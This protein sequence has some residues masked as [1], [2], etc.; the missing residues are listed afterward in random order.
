VT[1]IAVVIDHVSKKFRRGQ[2]HDSLRDLVP[3]LARR[4]IRRP[5]PDE[6]RGQEFWALR[7]VHFEVERGQA[8][9]IVG[10]NGAGKSTILKLLCGIIHPT[11]GSVRVEGRRSGLL[12]IG[13]GFH[14]DL[15]GRENIFLNGVILG[16]SR[17]E[18]ERK[19]DEI[20]DFS[21]VAEFIDTPVKRYSSGMFARLGFSVA[22]HLEPDILI[23]DEVLSVGDF[24]FQKKSLAKMTALAAGGA[25]VLFVSH[26]LKAVVDLCQHCA[27][28][29]HGKV[30][31]IGP[32]S[33]V[34]HGYLSKEREVHSG[35][36]A[37]VRI[38]R[39]SVR[40]PDGP[41]RTFNSG[42]CAVVDVELT[43]ARA[44]KGLSV[45][46]ALFDESFYG[47]FWATTERLGR[48]AFSLD[49]GESAVV[50]FRL[51]LHLGKGRFDIGAEVLRRD[52]Q[53]SYDRWEHAASIF[54]ECER[55]AAGVVDL[56]PQAEVLGPAIT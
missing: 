38:S 34:L 51:V 17:R 25:T 6:L 29:D 11:L 19:F 31:A 26:N 42:E 5:H 1:D 45:G 52:I 12:E 8:F 37:D 16:M 56:E 9:G 4:V 40:S 14:P 54:V 27:V 23:V 36:Q 55:D 41:R 21:G 7:D 2:L 30:V 46:L 32:S 44:V 20:V 43:A 49:P 28:L 48:S 15:T 13:A 22:A 47:V 10:H 24:L 50:S 3:A 33:E 53:K 35:E 18:I 39:V